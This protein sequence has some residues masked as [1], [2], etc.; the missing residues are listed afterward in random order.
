MPLSSL[1][2]PRLLVDE[3][4]LQQNISRMQARADREDVALRPHTK[5]HKSVAVARRQL[6]AGAAGITVAKPAEAEVF[7]EAGFGDIRLAYTVV[8]E[9]KYARLQ[10][11]REGGVE[12]S[13]CI[14]TPEGARLASSYY[15]D[16]APAEV[17]M[18]I[19]VGQG[20]CG[21]NW[22]HHDEIVSLAREVEELE[23]LLLAGILT[24][25]GQAYYGPKEG[26]SPVEA[27]WRVS[28]QEG[29]RMLSVAGVLN[30]AGVDAAR[31]GAFEISVGSTPT[32]SHFQ[33]QTAADFTITDIRPG[34]Y[35]YF[36]AM[37][38][39]LGSC[40]WDD[41]ALT[42]LA[43]VI[44]KR[45]ADD[46]T[47]RLYLDAGKKVFTSDK[48]YLQDGHGALLDQTMPR[49]VQ[50]DAII[51]ALSEEHGWVRTEEPIGH[52]V[53]DRVRVIP[54]HACTAVHTQDELVLMKEG[55]P[56]GELTIDARWAST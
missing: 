17:L 27:L 10:R 28:Q 50:G 12:V 35:V 32:A 46:G 23:G 49:V 5:T 11:L 55:E 43:T 39:S 7:A 53:G 9:E 38:V 47:E 56:V 24:H 20:R 4:R 48:G 52:E 54:N 2:T 1:A 31:P 26:E 36:D 37:Q 13:F 40:Q 30:E 33:N 34:N 21:I 22:Q 44:S 8:G 19:D 41:C 29:S 15:E 45:A 14:D 6:K 18:E 25:A 51:H 16:K 3:H 42:V